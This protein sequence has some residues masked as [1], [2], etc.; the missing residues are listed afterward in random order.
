MVHLI[1]FVLLQFMFMLTYTVTVLRPTTDP[2]RSRRTNRER[3]AGKQCTCCRGV[4]EASAPLPKVGRRETMGVRRGS[5]SPRQVLHGSRRSSARLQSRIE[6]HLVTPCADNTS[7]YV[8]NNIRPFTS[9]MVS[10]ANII[11]MNLQSY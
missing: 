7:T 9:C 3:D 11:N 6:P 5:N 8:I 10:H 2:N 1:C 4:H